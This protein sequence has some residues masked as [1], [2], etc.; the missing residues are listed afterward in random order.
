MAMPF[1]LA[2]LVSHYK[3]SSNHQ[4]TH[5]KFTQFLLVK[6]A[7]IKME[8]EKLGNLDNFCLICFFS[9]SV[10]ANV[11]QNQKVKDENLKGVIHA[12]LLG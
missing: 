3:L 5:F 1:A 10:K 7:S 6:Y 12:L 2:A 9:P 4:A 11:F 8:N